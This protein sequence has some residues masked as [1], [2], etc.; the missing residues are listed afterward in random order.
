MAYGKIKADSIVYD[1][2]GSDVEKTIASLATGAP[3]GSPAFTGT[4]TAPTASSGTNT[5]Q[6]ATTAFVNA[7]SAPTASPAFTGTPTAPTAAAATNTTQLATTAFVT[8][9]IANLSDSAPSTLDTLNELA[10]ALGDDAN[11]STTVT[12]SIA[13]KAPLASPNFTGIPVARGD[14]SSTDGQIQLNCS[15]N[16]HGVKIK[17][18]PHSAG[19][20]YTLTLPNDTGTS[21]EALLTDGSG[22]LSWGAGGIPA[23]GGT[24]TGDVTFNEIIKINGAKEHVDLKAGIPASGTQNFS[25]KDEAIRYYTGNT[26]SDYTPNLRGDGSTTLNNLMSV[27]ESLTCVY[28]VT[29]G[30]TAYKLAGVQIDGSTSGVTVRYVGGAP[31]SAG[32][33]N[34]I[35]A[36]TITVIKTANATFTVLV[37]QAEY[38]A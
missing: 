36:S 4:P 22:A 1:N 26:T 12:N 3:L 28:I 6:I 19:A 20:S 10:A 9:A 5:T 21:G 7:N 31:S 27:G 16:S 2:N 18:P 13:A 11:F 15:Q 29:Y 14:G 33:A 32:T 35:C 25:F 8:G 34:S 24:F 37:S 17:S 23:T 30:S 38:E